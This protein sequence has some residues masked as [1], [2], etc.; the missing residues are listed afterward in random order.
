MV[1]DWKDA[2]KLD[3]EGQKLLGVIIDQYQDSKEG[4]PTNPNSMVYAAYV[5]IRSEQDFKYF[6]QL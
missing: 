1:F 2:G 4:L 3:E 6:V 5:T